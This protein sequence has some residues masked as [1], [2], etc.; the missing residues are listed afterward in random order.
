MMTHLTSKR[1]F[2]ESNRLFSFSSRE[3]YLLAL[4]N[5]LTSVVS[6]ISDEV[7]KQTE[8]ALGNC[9][10]NESDLVRQLASNCKEILLSS[11]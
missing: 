9:Q 5:C 7:K 8:Q 6:K 1:F 10:S 3:T 2:F 4:K 11:N